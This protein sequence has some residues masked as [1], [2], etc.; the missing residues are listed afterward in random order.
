MAQSPPIQGKANDP[1]GQVAPGKFAEKVIPD[2]EQRGEVYGGSGQGAESGSAGEMDQVKL[3]EAIST[4]QE[5]AR[6]FEE[7][8]GM[9]SP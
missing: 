9:E 4:A 3:N 7:G 1:M 5:T 2:K 8:K 6:K